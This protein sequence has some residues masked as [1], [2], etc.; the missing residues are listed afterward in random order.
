[1]LMLLSPAKSLDFERPS[2][3]LDLTS[4]VLEAEAAVLAACLR[5]MS[6]RELSQL[7]DLSDALASLNVERF[8]QWE[9]GVRTTPEAR[10]ALLAFD[11]DVYAGLQADTLKT[12]A[13]K[14]AQDHAFILSGLYGFLRPLDALQPYRLEMG[15]RLKTARGGDLYEFWGHRV[16]NAINEQL[17][18]LAKKREPSVLLNLASQ[19]YAK[20]VRAK[21]GAPKAHDPGGPGLQAE[22]LIS[23]VFEDEQATG[24]YKVVS[25]F[26]KRAR[27]LMARFVIENRIL[28]PEVLTEFESEGYQ[29][30]REASRPNQPVFRRKRA[31]QAA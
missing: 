4:P 13:L 12:A 25:F 22:Q 6:T 29:W 17:R 28:R 8:A 14:W 21:P 16:T 24:G 1:M 2:P 30:V 18:S 11:G 20:V 26:A 9:V 27:G 5:K 15:T 3:K 31:A 23:P 19:E 10:H 7:M